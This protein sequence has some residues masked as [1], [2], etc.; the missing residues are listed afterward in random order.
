MQNYGKKSGFSHSLEKFTTF[1]YMEL[2]FVSF[3]Q[4][5]LNR[6]NKVMKLLQGQGAIDELGLGRIRDAFS[7]AM[8]PGMSVLQTRAKYFCLL[9]AL[10]SFLERTRISDAREARAKIREYEISLTRRLIAKSPGEP[11][12]IGA[13]SLSQRGGYVKYDPTYVYLAGLETYGLVKSGGNIYATLAERSAAYVLAPRKEQGSEDTG[14]DSDDLNGFAQLFL[15]CATDYKF[16]SNEPIPIKLSRTEAEFLKERIIRSTS[17]SLL[18]YLLD[19]GLYVEATESYIS[20]KDLGAIIEHKVPEAIW[21]CYTLALRYSRYADLLRTRFAYLYD[22]AVGADDAAEDELTQF[23]CKLQ[24]HADEFT[25]AAIAEII[26]FINSRVTDEKS[27]NFILK[28]AE[29]IAAGEFSRLDELICKRE[30][31]I[32]GIRRSK[33]MNAR[34]FEQGKAFEKPG[35]M[36]YRWNTT[37]FSM[38][39]E[40]KEGMRNE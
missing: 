21:T 38:L 24:E 37:V 2:G 25:P 30:Q 34:E 10:Y 7:N 8:F 19:S 33:L 13:D 29:A 27:K 5:A 15:A 11:G 20:F 17:G 6:A 4:E 1:A 22:I 12:I 40:I 16:H 39:N 9:P 35:P 31:N 26:S 14:D 23:E 36:S 32:K 3:N 28:T 18:H